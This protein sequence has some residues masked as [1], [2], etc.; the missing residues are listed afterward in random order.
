MVLTGVKRRL[1]A[2]LPAPL[3]C[4]DLRT[5]PTRTR[6][7][8]WTMGAALLR[9][10]GATMMLVAVAA[11]TSG[12]AATSAASLTH[13]DVEALVK[14]A[15]AAAQAQ[16]VDALGELLAANVRIEL[17]ISA[18]GD[19]QTMHLNRDEYLQ[20]NREG[21]AQASGYEL[22][23]GTPTITIAADGKTAEVKQ[24]STERVTMMGQRLISK[25][26]SVSQV[27]ATPD[28]PKYVWIKASST[29]GVE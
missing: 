3:S 29:I 13:G 25:S 9:I 14:R 8:R 4:T 19:V 26:R 7:G 6:Q 2:Q 1:H 22:I 20:Q 28:G 23:P 21:F 5:I 12:E 27:Q 11:C 15:D 17:T 10:V 18:G 16:D 24:S